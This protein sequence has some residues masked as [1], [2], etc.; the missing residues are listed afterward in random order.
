MECPESSA[1]DWQDREIAIQDEPGPPDIQ[2]ADDPTPHP[3][4]ETRRTGH[5]EN[6]SETD[7]AEQRGRYVQQQPV[8]ERRIRFDDIDRLASEVR[9]LTERQDGLISLLN[10][11]LQVQSPIK[12]VSETDLSGHITPGE[13]T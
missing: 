2:I 8:E 6:V 12:P 5:K 10:L 1:T 3:L 9:K 13:L 11:S 7:R 4:Y